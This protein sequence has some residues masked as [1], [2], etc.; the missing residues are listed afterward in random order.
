MCQANEW[1]KVIKDPLRYPN[2]A[3]PKHTSQYCQAG[4]SGRSAKEYHC[5]DDR[6][7]RQNEPDGSHEALIALLV[8]PTS[9]GEVAPPVIEH[10]VDAMQQPPK[11]EQVTCPMPETRY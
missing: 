7:K 4:A 2:P 6:E 1:T 10:K 5:K 9:R 3:L 8:Y 11:D